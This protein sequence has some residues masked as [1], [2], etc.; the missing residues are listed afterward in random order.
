MTERGDGPLFADKTRNDG[1]P[2]GAESLVNRLRDWIREIV[3]DLNVAPNHAWRH[4]VK[5]QFRDLR[6]EQRVADV[7]QGWSEEDA[8][9]AGS[10][11]GEVSLKAKIDA[12]AAIPC[13][14]LQ[15]VTTSGT[16]LLGH[17]T[18]SARINADESQRS[19]LS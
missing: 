10:S 16:H 17:D 14:E 18:T 12:I 7:I 4:R 11:Y 19:N 2:V 1:M 13:Y 6:I 15:R 9:N 8:N 5:T 3:P